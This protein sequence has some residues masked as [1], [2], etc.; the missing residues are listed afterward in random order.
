M[1]HFFMTCIL[2]YDMH[3]LLRHVRYCKKIGAKV[4]G[5]CRQGFRLWSVKR[6]LRQDFCDSVLNTL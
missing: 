2:F 4:T 6:V 5:H 3:F 1:M